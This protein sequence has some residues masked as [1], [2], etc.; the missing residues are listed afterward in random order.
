[1]D[2]GKP[3][4]GLIQASLIAL[5]VISAPVNAGDKSKLTIPKPAIQ[6]KQHAGS[7]NINTASVEQLQSLKGIGLAK[8]AAIVEFRKKYGN[9]NSIDDLK[10]VKGLGEKFLAKNKDKIK[11]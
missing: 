8:A 2:R 1:M 11:L 3:M 10:K 9:F 4:K 7:V 6:L 5:A